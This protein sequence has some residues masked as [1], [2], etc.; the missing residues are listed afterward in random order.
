MKYRNSLNP[1]HN[2]IRTFRLESERHLLYP[3]FF[4]TG[5][6]N[7]YS[8]D[9]RYC[10]KTCH[11]AQNVSRHLP[12]TG[13]SLRLVMLSI[14]PLLIVTIISLCACSRK[15]LVP[16]YSEEL[17][18]SQTSTGADYIPTDWNIIDRGELQVLAKGFHETGSKRHSVYSVGIES[19]GMRQGTARQMALVRQLFSG[20]QHVQLGATTRSTWMPSE[21]T[22]TRV[23]A[24]L[25]G[26]A[27]KC[28]VFSQ[29][30]QECLIEQAFWINSSSQWLH[31][32][33]TE[34]LLF[35]ELK[36]LP[37]WSRYESAHIEND[38]EEQAP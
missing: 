29:F 31:T 16:R 23:S 4:R 32:E 19:C 9:R 12:K 13:V 24:A 2:F 10:Q 27:M 8:S 3:S 21:M 1:F 33:T 14:S 7:S 36:N 28:I 11:D 20:F 35:S 30:F 5:P 15:A 34:R 37:P 6:S 25:D 26:K 38:A 22:L 17:Q 18:S